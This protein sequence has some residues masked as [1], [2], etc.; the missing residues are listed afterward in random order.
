M[1]EVLSI[2]AGVLPLFLLSAAGAVV[3]RLGI[4]TA[5]AD[6]TLLGL[7]VHLLMPCLILDHVVASEA[8]RHS[9]NLF[10]SPGLG[11]VTAALG[12]LLAS[13]VA[14]L[15]RFGSLSQARTFS[16]TAGI[17]NYGYIP[18]PLIEVLYGPEA[19]SV[20][21]L[22]NLGTEIAF[23][24]VGFSLLEGRSMFGD[25]RRALTTPVRAI[26]L[27]VAINLFTAAF[28]YRLD[29]LTLQSVSWG[30]PVA[31]VMSTIHLIGSCTIPM[32]MMLIGA[33]M[34]DFWNEFRATRAFGVMTLAV[35]FRN[36]LGPLVFIVPILLLP[37]SRELQVTLVVQAAMPA[38]IFPLL[39]ARHHG[40]NV[41]VALQVI[42]STS[43]VGLVTLPLWI[44]FGMH[45]VAAK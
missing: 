24:L 38:A 4:L 10:W 14:R 3:R 27:A 41:P 11:F 9:G 1:R 36:L 12:V 8:L 26:L 40:G 45:L 18:V 37:I 20:L 30:W 22:F 43:A 28:G 35:I 17:N 23:W 31:I 7:L 13:W 44:H 33:T 39:L 29:P 21:F 15:A 34:A 6:R 19:L 42:F 16:F 5:Q 2:L 32:A 25:W